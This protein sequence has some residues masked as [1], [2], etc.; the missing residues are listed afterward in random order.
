MPISIL[1]VVSMLGGVL[2]PR[3]LVPSAFQ[4]AGRDVVEVH[5][6]VTVAG[7]PRIHTGVPDERS[8]P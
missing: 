6:L 5:S 7:Q 8:A 2:A 4:P 1:V 3:S